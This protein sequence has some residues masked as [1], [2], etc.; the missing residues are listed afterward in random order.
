MPET[1]KTIP[2]FP[3]YAVSDAGNIRRVRDNMGIPLKPRHDTEGYL[4]VSLCSRGRVFTRKVHHLVLEAFVGPRP[5]GCEC[6]H[7]NTIRDDNRIENLR[8]VSHGENVL[9]PESRRNYERG[10]KSRRSNR[11]VR[12]LETGTVFDTLAAAARN[13]GVSRQRIWLLCHDPTRTHRGLH[14]VYTGV[15]HA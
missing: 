9:N 1:W 2:G 12:C 11:Q 8:W 6:D 7:I 5:D 3:A 15:C 13:F 4:L 14:F 10:Y